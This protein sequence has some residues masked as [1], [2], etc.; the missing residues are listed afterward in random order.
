MIGLQCDAPYRGHE[1][2]LFLQVSHK[3]QNDMSV[4]N[5]SLLRHLPVRLCKEA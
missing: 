5:N 4:F 3:I 2:N 1:T